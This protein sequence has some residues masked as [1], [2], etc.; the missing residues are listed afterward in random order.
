M[1]EVMLVLTLGIDGF[2]PELLADLG[3]EVEDCFGQQR[4]CRTI[5]REKNADRFE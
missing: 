2:L 3:V 5:G 4:I 1:G